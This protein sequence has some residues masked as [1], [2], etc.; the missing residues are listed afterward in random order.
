MHM[1]KTNEIIKCRPLESLTWKVLGELS[2]SRWR[3][4]HSIGRFAADKLV[5]ASKRYLEKKVPVMKL[6]IIQRFSPK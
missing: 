3:F 1:P 5:V 2:P 4:E 6:K